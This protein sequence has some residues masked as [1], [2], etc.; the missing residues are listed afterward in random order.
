MSGWKVHVLNQVNQET[1]LC[2]A[3]DTGRKQVMFFSVGSLSIRTS[4]PK[5]IDGHFCPHR[6][7]SAN[8]VN[9]EEKS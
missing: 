9:T 8:E 1:K 3:K 4:K 7:K 5:V 2:T 6:D